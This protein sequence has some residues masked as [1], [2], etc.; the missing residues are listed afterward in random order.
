MTEADPD[1]LRY[2]QREAADAVVERLQ[3][4][5]S[6]LIDL[7][8]GLGKTQVF[9]AIAKH[10]PGDVL[11]LAH[12]NELIEQAR[13]RLE[14]MTGQH[15]EI[16]KAESRSS[17]TCRLVVGSV[18]SFNARRLEGFARDRFSLIIVDEAHHA[19]SP[20]YTRIFDWFGASK[21]L[22]V[23]ATPD[24][25]DGSALGKVFESVAYRMG[26]EDGIDAGY[27][28]PLEVYPMHIDKLD[29][30]DVGKTGKD[31]AAGEL[32]EK[33]LEV[34]EPIARGIIEHGEG[35][36]G[37]A[38]LPGVKSAAL[39][40]ERL[41]ILEPDCARFVSG[42]TPFD[43]RQL[44]M[45]RFREGRFRLLCNCQ[46]A[47]EGFDSPPASLIVLGRH[48][49]SRSLVAQMVG[50]GTR[51]V[52]PAVNEIPGADGA[53]ARRLE[54]EWSSKPNL[55]VIDCVGNVG[56]HSL[57]SPLDA[58]AGNYTEAEIKLARKKK[59]KSP[60]QNLREA[61][62][63][64]RALAAAVDAKAKTRLGDRIDPFSVLKVDRGSI[65]AFEESYGRSPP[66]SG[67][68]WAARMRGMTSGDLNG[69][70]KHALSKLLERD[71]GREAKGW[72]PYSM[73]RVLRRFPGMPENVRTE[74][75]QAAIEAVQ[76]KW[77]Y[78]SSIDPAEI[79]RVAK[80]E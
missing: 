17:G 55:L 54:V 43:E 26:M 16:E 45:Q 67:Q 36:Q 75:A 32:D 11:V 40:A 10:W 66:T 30:S 38:F 28:V 61:R 51:T 24:R 68:V 63:E 34:V 72:A 27:L 76:R 50:R 69:L 19:T 8:T 71:K 20:S 74:H 13:D 37:I 42:D 5:R 9:S 78:P 47:T 23:T 44:I 12:R 79:V 53:E 73:M 49:L 15:V 25:A 39:C 21:L 2:Y 52:A 70:S 14:Q 3:E 7:A 80:G 31:L 33:M 22:G 35:R 56:K 1:G 77:G 59:G 64:L 29:I 60:L 57:A 62:A 18:Q 65:E 48:T 41:N 46:V 58:L 4:D 6:T